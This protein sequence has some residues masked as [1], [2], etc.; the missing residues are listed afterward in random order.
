MKKEN[1][2]IY[3][4]FV[5]YIFKSYHF[6]INSYDT[7]L[8]TFRLKDICV[9]TYTKYDTF[10]NELKDWTELSVEE[11]KWPINISESLTVSKLR[12]HTLK[13]L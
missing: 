13:C 1:E 5:L 7:E 6:S 4:D 9:C 11:M 8:V 3:D 10:Q 2:I 12:K